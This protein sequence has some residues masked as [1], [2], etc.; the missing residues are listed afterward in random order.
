MDHTSDGSG[1]SLAAAS[2][3]LAGRE[4]R[5]PKCPVRQPILSGWH[6]GHWDL[7]LLEIAHS[8]GPD[9]PSA[10]LSTDPSNGPI[11]AWAGGLFPVLALAESAGL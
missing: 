11:G 5:L 8:G 7:N 4:I 3:A 9:I 1:R 6:T 10:G 2:N